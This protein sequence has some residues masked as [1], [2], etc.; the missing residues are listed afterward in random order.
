MEKIFLLVCEGPTDFYVIEKIASQLEANTGNKITIR[1]LSPRPGNNNEWPAQGW[2]GVRKWC[3]IYGNTR[4]DIVQA[5]PLPAM[6]AAVRRYNWRALVK[7][8]NADGIIIQIDSDIAEEVSAPESFD[9]NT[10]H[11]RHHLEGAI[12]YWLNEPIDSDN[13]YLAV[14]SYALEAWILATHNRNH[15]AFANLA[16]GFNYEEIEDPEARMIALGYETVIKAGRNRIKKSEGNYKIYGATV[17]NNLQVVRQECRSA[18]ELCTHL[19][20]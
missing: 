12:S 10:D 2:T 17:A 9:P 14:T 19:E 6:Q 3:E 4:E 5:I 13:T 8:A 18:D 16:H 11:R 1:P 15:P 7:G 20:S